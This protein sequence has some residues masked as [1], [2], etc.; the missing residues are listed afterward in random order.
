MNS[1]KD[2]ASRRSVKTHPSAGREEGAK[3]F[4]QRLLNEGTVQVIRVSST[5]GQVG[6]TSP[7]YQMNDK[8]MY[9]ISS[10]KR[11]PRLYAGIQGTVQVINAGPQTLGPR[12]GRG[13]K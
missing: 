3:H 2:N 1:I 11:R 7:G 10:Y 8:Y 4:V 5:S 12:C 6:R 13:M 9:P